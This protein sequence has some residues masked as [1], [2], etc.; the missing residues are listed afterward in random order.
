MNSVAQISLDNDIK[1]QIDG[2][3]AVSNRVWKVKFGDGKGHPVIRIDDADS[4]RWIS[5]G[6]PI[7]KQRPKRKRSKKR[8]ELEVND[9]CTSNID[10]GDKDG[11]CY[12]K[13]TW[14]IK[15]RPRGVVA[16]PVRA[17]GLEL[18]IEDGKGEIGYY[19]EGE[20]EARFTVGDVTAVDAN[21]KEL[22]IVIRQQDTLLVY[23]PAV[24]TWADYAYPMVVD[25]TITTTTNTW[26]FWSAYPYLEYVNG[27]WWCAFYDGTSPV[28]YQS[29][30]GSS[31]AQVSTGNTSD[32]IFTTPDP[33]V[34]KWSVKFD[35]AN[36]LM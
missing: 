10:T 1:S 30:D 5:F 6:S 20:W 25:P 18:K 31:W 16:T 19:E 22:D 7:G 32:H 34:N 28:L 33:D 12:I 15:R 4:G 9:N 11:K 8:I 36:N 29:S 24:G 14:T 35:A 17:A 3:Y 2:S 27:R 23:E 21:E 13:E 26:A